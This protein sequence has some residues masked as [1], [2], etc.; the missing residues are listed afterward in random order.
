VAEGDAARS[1]DR[2]QRRREA[3]ALLLATGNSIRQAAAQSGVAARTI[4]RWHL[5]DAFRLRVSHLRGEIFDRAVGRLTQVAGKAADT[6]V[7]LLDS[8][9]E[10]MRFRAARAILEMVPQLRAGNELEQRLAALEAAEGLRPSGSELRVPPGC[11]IPPLGEAES[12]R[13]GRQQ[14]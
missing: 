6:L 9:D 14:G 13:G 4:S 2:T 7:A 1:E 8:G 10:G 12:P 5:D 11:E 3:V